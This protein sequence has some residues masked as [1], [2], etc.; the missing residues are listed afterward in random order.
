M[1]GKSCYAILGI[2][3]T[4]TQIEIEAA[5]RRLERLYAPENDAS[6]FAAKIYAEASWAWEVLRDA[7]SRSLYDAEHPEFFAPPEPP[8]EAYTPP[9]NFER[10]Q[11]EPLVRR[12]RW[13][14][15]ET[16][17]DEETDFTPREYLSRPAVPWVVAASVVALLAF[18]LL[19]G[20]VD[21]SRVG[22]LLLRTVVMLCAIWA[23]YFALRV[24]VVA[25][26]WLPAYI[27]LCGIAYTF[28]NYSI[29]LERYVFHPSRWFPQSV[30]R[31][32]L[33]RHANK[34]S[35]AFLLAF[36]FFVL[37]ETAAIYLEK[38][39]YLDNLRHCRKF[40]TGRFN[41]P[42]R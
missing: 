10:P 9:Q 8:Q 5:W 31:I 19:F 21:M 42:E 32:A 35:L 13:E 41:R 29:L 33:Q 12:E 17:Q 3:P 6:P 7:A 28:A 39:N 24:R 40:L 18:H 4:A 20:W 25:R 27:L 14:G 15:S 37:F 36:A 2:P 1:S 16:V 11:Y 38:G 22:T 26:E 23:G 30:G 34:P